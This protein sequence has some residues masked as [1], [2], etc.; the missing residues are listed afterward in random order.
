MKELWDGLQEIKRNVVTFSVWQ[1]FLT[2]VENWNKNW[3]QIST[4]DTI[5]FLNIQFLRK[6]WKISGNQRKLIDWVSVE[7]EEKGR[8]INKIY[9]HTLA[10]LL[11]PT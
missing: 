10:V 9:G 7:K 1:L 3:I 4:T 11:S 2:R 5:K 8:I 6:F